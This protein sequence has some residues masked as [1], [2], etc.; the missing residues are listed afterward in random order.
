MTATATSLAC[1][2]CDEAVEFMPFSIETKHDTTGARRIPG[3]GTVIKPLGSALT[4]TEL[5]EMGARSKA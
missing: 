2:N 3:D 5:V 1:P 4:D